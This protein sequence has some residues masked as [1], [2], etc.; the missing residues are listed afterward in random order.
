[1]KNNQAFTLIELLVV[2]LIIG[3]LA[4]VALPKYEQAVAKSRFV[5]LQTIGNAIATSQEAYYLANGEY[6]TSFDQLDI[7]P[8]G[9]LGYSAGN[10]RLITISN[11]RCF[12][13][14]D[15]PHIVCYWK[16]G[17][18]NNDLSHSQLSKS[19]V[20]PMDVW[21]GTSGT[22]IRRCIGMT[23]EQ[24]K[25]CLSLGGTLIDDGNNRYFVLP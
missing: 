11:V 13:D 12:F 20:P 7:L 9:T 6:A 5:Q 17:T 22:I 15:Y 25:T 18:D 10:N 21:Y 2:V 3:I 1:M 4:A 23:D 19:K 8:N 14:G 16:L 24:R